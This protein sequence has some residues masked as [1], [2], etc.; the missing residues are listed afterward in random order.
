MSALF[1][2]PLPV[3]KRKRG[4]PPNP[5]LR[6][7]KHARMLRTAMELF[8]SRGYEHVTVEQ[9]AQAA[10]QSKGAFYWYFKDKEDCLRQIIGNVAN[11]IDG[12]AE[13]ELGKGGTASEKLLRLTDLKN[14]KE[15]DL[16]N[17][18]MLFDSMIFSRSSTVRE[19]GIQA[20]SQIYHSL[21]LRLKDLG[22]AAARESGWTAEQ[23]K[24]HDFDHWA[25]L[26]LTCYNGLFEFINQKY[27]DQMPE[28]ERTT[29]VIHTAFVHPIVSARRKEHGAP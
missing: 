26:I 14:W 1:E 25:L 8:I 15:S 7:A 21:F 2:N 13:G 19:L 5:A 17:F 27:F 12:I 24:S 10:G 28:V 22:V 18:V 3:R 11:K 9:I 16:S 20:V 6:A 23:I 29:R 4:R